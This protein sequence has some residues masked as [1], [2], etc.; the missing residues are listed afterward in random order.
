MENTVVQ[1]KR[2]RSKV[3]LRKEHLRGKEEKDSRDRRYPI[4]ALYPRERPKERNSK[5]RGQEDDRK[6]NWKS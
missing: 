1:F 4:C 2:E 6:I 3:K 5:D